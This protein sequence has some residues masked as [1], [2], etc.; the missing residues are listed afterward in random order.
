MLGYTHYLSY[1]SG[2]L[3][4]YS[5]G[6]GMTIFAPVSIQIYTVATFPLTG[7]LKAGHPD[8]PECNFSQQQYV[9]WTIE[10][11]G[12][13]GIQS[14]QGQALFSLVRSMTVCIIGPAV[15]PYLII[16]ATSYQILAS[17]TCKID[18]NRIQNSAFSPFSGIAHPQYPLSNWH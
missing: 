18:F 4:I 8:A 6:L 5:N 14:N 2:T 3:T 15:T 17:F 13:L 10:I 1:F 7:Y 9:R 11:D 16:N 12:T